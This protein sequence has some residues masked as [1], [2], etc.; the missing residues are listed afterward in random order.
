MPCVFFTKELILYLFNEKK[1]S[2]ILVLEKDGILNK[3]TYS[4]PNGSSGYRLEQILFSSKSSL[5]QFQH[6]RTISDLPASF[7]RP[8]LYA[9]CEMKKN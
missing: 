6:V 3:R 9:I 5:Y 1:L 8:I 7:Q 4:I 2:D